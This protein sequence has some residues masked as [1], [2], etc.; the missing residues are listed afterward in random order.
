M[1]NMPLAQA[2]RNER[3]NGLVKQLIA[4]IAKHLLGLAVEFD[5]QPTLIN[6]KDRV[7]SVVEKLV[8]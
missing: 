7:G 2:F 3:L 4:T 1:F 6:D 8:G 5:D